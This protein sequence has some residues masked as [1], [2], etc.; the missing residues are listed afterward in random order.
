[1]RKVSSDNDDDDDEM[2]T[3]KEENWI[4]RRARKCG[5]R[6]QKATQTKQHFIHSSA[7]KL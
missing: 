4:E 1:M 6:R 5:S 7:L 3:R 2:E